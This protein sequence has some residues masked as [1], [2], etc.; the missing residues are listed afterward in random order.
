MKGVFMS[1]ERPFDKLKSED[2]SDVFYLSE[3]IL[4]FYSATQVAIKVNEWFCM[5]PTTSY[6]DRITIPKEPNDQEK[7]EW[8]FRAEITVCMELL[9]LQ[10]AL[11]DYFQSIVDE[12]HPTKK[13]AQKQ[14]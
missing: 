6:P 4:F 13:K 12:F 5:F 3:D 1:E 11:N 14:P 8:E 2:F 10:K 7:Q 9:K